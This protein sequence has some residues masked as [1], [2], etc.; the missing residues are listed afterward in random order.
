MR[1]CDKRNTAVLRGNYRSR[2]F[3]ISY[4]IAYKDLRRKGSCCYFYSRTLRIS[5]QKIAKR[6]FKKA[7]HIYLSSA[8][9]NANS[10]P[11]CSASKTHCYISDKC[12]FPHT[13]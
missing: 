11:F 10:K 13:R 4:L 1:R 2:F 9:H 12:C 5:F 8:I 3:F 7:F 6:M